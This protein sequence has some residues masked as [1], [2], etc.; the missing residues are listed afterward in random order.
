VPDCR[1]TVVVD[2]ATGDAWDRLAD[3]PAWPSWN[4][5]C[6]DAELRGDLTPGTQ[7]R[8]RL[9]H[10]KGRDFFTRPRLTEVERPSRLAWEARSVGLRARTALEVEPE[11]GGSRITLTAESGGPLGFS[12]RWAMR[13]RTQALIYGAML[14]GLA[15]SFR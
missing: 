10:P 4:P 6:L 13:P 15:G 2:A 9:R 5:A 7:L 14:D 8:L 1:V 11:E 3:I 12:Y